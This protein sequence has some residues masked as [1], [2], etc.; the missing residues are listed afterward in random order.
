MKRDAALRAEGQPAV[1]FGYVDPA[2]ATVETVAGTDQ[3]TELYRRLLARD[4]LQAEVDALLGLHAAVLAEGGINA[5][6]L[7]LSCFAIGSTTK[8]LTC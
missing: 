1:V 8:A 7:L 5:D 2:G 4:P 3:L 6:W